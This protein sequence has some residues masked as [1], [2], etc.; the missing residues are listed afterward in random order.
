M[1]QPKDTEF[2]EF[3]PISNFAFIKE[4]RDACDSTGIHERVALW[5]IS[6]FMKKQASSSL[7]ASQSPRK[8][9]STGVHGE[10]LRS[11]GERVSSCLTKFAANDKIVQAVKSQRLFDNVPV[12]LSRCTC[13]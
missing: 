12:Y 9:T 6:H 7:A 1:A 10:K 8:S 5:L 2:D 11:F 13:V 4:Y 3:D